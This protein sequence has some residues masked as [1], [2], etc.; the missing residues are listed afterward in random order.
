MSLRL[1]EL[2]ANAQFER[3]KESSIRFICILDAQDDGE[4]EGFWM[5]LLQWV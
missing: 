4:H 1:A 3:T 2:G 5:T